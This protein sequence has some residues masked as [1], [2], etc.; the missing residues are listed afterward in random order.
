MSSM[1][2]LKSTNE[3][4][5]ELTVHFSLG[6]SVSTPNEDLKQ[7]VD[8][9]LSQVDPDV[10]CAIDYLESLVDENLFTCIRCSYA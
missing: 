4:L 5:C 1:L 8:H 10:E 6:S 9:G 3:F 7:P 2:H